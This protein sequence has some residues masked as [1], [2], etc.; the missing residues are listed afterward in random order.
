VD[1]KLARTNLA[2]DDPS[3]GRTEIHGRVGTPGRRMTHVGSP[4]SS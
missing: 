1:A 3:V 4:W 2:D